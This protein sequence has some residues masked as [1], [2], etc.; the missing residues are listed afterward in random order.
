MFSLIVRS[1]QGLNNAIA[2]RKATFDKYGEYGLKEGI[3]NHEGSKRFI[4]KDS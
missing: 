3:P 4:I 2:E 1:Y